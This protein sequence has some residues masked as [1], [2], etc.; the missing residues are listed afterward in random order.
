MEELS[1]L[2]REL[3]LVRERYAKLLDAHREIQKQNCLL[4]E[5]ILVIVEDSSNDKENLRHAQEE[6]CH[7]KETIKASEHEKQRYR[8]DCN[9]AVKLLQQNPTEFLSNTSSQNMVIP[10]FPP[11]C[12]SA[13]TLVN[14]QAPA[15]V[16][17]SHSLKHFVCSN[18]HRITQCSD[19]SVQ[20]SPILSTSILCDSHSNMTINEYHRW[21][22]TKI[23][24]DVGISSNPMPQMH[25]V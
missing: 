21:N 16:D 19:A 7:L 6:I 1:A 24:Q 11:I 23:S 3:E 10:T 20:T 13:Y 12:A 9:L 25:T 15:V 17:D 4:E 14:H 2:K 8:N 22:S 18:C 5:R